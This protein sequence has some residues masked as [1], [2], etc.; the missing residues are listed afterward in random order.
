MRELVLPEC[1][2]SVQA[3]ASLQSKGSPEKWWELTRHRGW[4]IDR[5]AKLVSAYFGDSGSFAWDNGGDYVVCQ[6]YAWLPRRKEPLSTGVSLAY[7]AIL[8]SQLFSELLSATSNN[9]GGGQWNLSTKFVNAIAIPEITDGAV[10]SVSA[11]ATLCEIGEQIHSGKMS[12]VDKELY[13]DTV[14][15]VYSVDYP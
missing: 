11:V 14:K 1:F 6:G 3:T 8:N 2:A 4:Q 5:S 9:V 12:Q 10:R 13:A 7:L 15:A